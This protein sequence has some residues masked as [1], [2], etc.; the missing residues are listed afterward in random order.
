MCLLQS[1]MAIKKKKKQFSILL[2]HLIG[3]FHTALIV[4]TIYWNMVDTQYDIFL[5]ANLVLF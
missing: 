1:Y 3:I 4:M 2:F 5:K